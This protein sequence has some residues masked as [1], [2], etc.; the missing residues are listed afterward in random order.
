MGEIRT[1]LDRNECTLKHLT[2]GGPKY[3]NLE[4]LWDSWDS[5]DLAFES[6]TIDNLTQ[7]H[8]VNTEVSHFVLSRI[9]SAF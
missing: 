1:M 9:A 8:L 6:V 4:P 5:W 2:L 3:L 7:L